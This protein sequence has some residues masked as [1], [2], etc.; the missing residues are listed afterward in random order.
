MCA[1]CRAMAPKHKQMLLSFAPRAA[2]PERR[3]E[4]AVVAARVDAALPPSNDNLAI[5]NPDPT[6]AKKSR[7]DL[8]LNTKHEIVKFRAS[9]TLQETLAHF[10]ETSRRAAMRAKFDAAKILKAVHARK[11]SVKRQRPLVKYAV[12]GE[13]LFEFFCMIRDAQGAVSRGLLEEYISS[14][15][16]EVQLDLMQKGDHRRDKFSCRW[17]AH[18][19]VVYRR[20]TAVKQFLPDD[21]TKR[22][23]TFHCLLRLIY[24]INKCVWG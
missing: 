7:R 15:P 8:S 4:G 5:G 3:G 9:H 21:Y 12:L 13:K 14:S 22:V 2:L 20:I 11:G 24:M 1:L 10:P 19:H 16:A 6:P 23:A 18:Y 17:R